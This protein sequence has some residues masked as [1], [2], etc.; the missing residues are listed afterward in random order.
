MKENIK[1]NEQFFN[2]HFEYKKKGLDLK[3]IREAVKSD[4]NITNDHL[5]RARLSALANPNRYQGRFVAIREF[6][7]NQKAPVQVSAEPGT[8]DVTEVMT[9]EDVGEV[10]TA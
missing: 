8:M 4:L 1:N 2:L 6:M 5:Y 10:Q 7:K 3:E 9:I